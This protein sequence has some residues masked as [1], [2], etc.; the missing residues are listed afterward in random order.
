MQSSVSRSGGERIEE[1]EELP[2]AAGR[3]PGVAPRLERGLA[4]MQGDR[5]IDPDGASGVELRAGDP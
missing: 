5:L 2:L 3:T 4:G 1:G